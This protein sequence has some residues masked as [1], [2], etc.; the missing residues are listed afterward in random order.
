MKHDIRDIGRR[1]QIQGDFLSA[2]PCGSGHIND[3]YVSAYEQDGAIVRYTHQRI[4]HKVFHDPA[5]LMDNMLRVTRHQMKKL[6]E[7]GCK[8]PSRRALTLLVTNDGLPYYRDNDGNF[9]RTYKFMENAL[10]VDFVETPDQA[11]QAAKAF[12]EF[13]RQLVDLPGARLHETIPDFHNTPKRF[14]ALEKAV[15]SDPANRAKGAAKEIAFALRHKAMTGILLSKHREGL[16]PERIVHNDTKVNNVLMDEESGEGLCVIDL[17]TVMPGLA[18]Y[19]FGDLAR[20]ATSPAAEDERDISKVRMQMPMFEALTA[21]YLGAA[22]GFLTDTEKEYLAFSGKLI[23][24]EIG[25]R[26]L[27]DFLMGDIYFKT[28]RPG[29]NLDRCRT[30][31]KLMESLV[32]QEDAMNEFVRSWSPCASSSLRETLSSVKMTPGLGA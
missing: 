31:F 5:R 32:E 2:A 14:E 3:T 25:I 7:S 20:T 28:H 16:I 6:A 26:F 24:F 27:A 19:D 30:Q 11:Y 13:Q 21:G 4:N 9:W 18:L 12:G 22:R 1:F 15:E 23:T 10:T 17:D 8:D 29:H